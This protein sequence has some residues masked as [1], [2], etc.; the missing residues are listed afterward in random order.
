MVRAYNYSNAIMI[1]NLGCEMIYVLH[2]RLQN[3]KV[4]APKIQKTILDISKTLFSEKIIKKLF[5]PKPLLGLEYIKSLLFQICHCSIIT[6]DIT[7]F[8]KLFEMILIGIKKQVLTSPNM[9]G[10]FHM[11]MNHLSNISSITS[12][13]ESLLTITKDFQKIFSEMNNYDFY[14]IRS[15]ILNSLNPKNVK[16]SFYLMDNSQSNDGNLIVQPPTNTGFNIEKIGT[17]FDGNKEVGNSGIAAT[18]PYQGVKGGTGSGGYK[19]EKSECGQNIFDAIERGEKGGSFVEGHKD[20]MLK[21]SLE[22]IAAIKGSNVGM[23]GLDDKI[24]LNF[25]D[26]YGGKFVSIGNTLVK[27][28]GLGGGGGGG[29]GG[30]GPGLVKS[31]TLMTKELN[32]KVDDI[33]AEIDGQMKKPKGKPGDEV[34]EESEDEMDGDDLLDLMDNL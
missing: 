22:L 30:S 14:M 16:V 21:E 31:E 34:T 23:G 20:Y 24:K 29:G 3:L 32:K 13:S 8:T 18:G 4:D 27:N 1:Y 9:H 15:F 6:L 5:E 17:R 7:S 19:G 12:D 33:F 28:S 11:T 2:H 10:I 26:M 25:D